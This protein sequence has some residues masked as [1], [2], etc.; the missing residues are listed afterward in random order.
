MSIE[1]SLR[2]QFFEGQYLGSDDLTAAVEYSRLQQERHRLGAHTWG[3]ALG[4][5]LIEVPS[6][7][8]GTAGDLYITPGYASDGLGRTVG[9]PTPYKL[10]L[11]RSELCHVPASGHTAA[12]S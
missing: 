8:G 1:Q 12:G 3:I 5:N 7:N 2:P 6:P 9:L 10:P 11:E 4:L